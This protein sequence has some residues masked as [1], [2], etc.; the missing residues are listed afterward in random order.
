MYSKTA[1]I[2]LIIGGLTFLYIP[3]VHMFGWNGS[4]PAEIASIISFIGIVLAATGFFI[5]RKKELE[6]MWVAILGA[7]LNILAI[8]IHFYFQSSKV[9]LS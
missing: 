9:T 1:I 8:L 3:F 7:I 5:V 4:D 6:G 2:S